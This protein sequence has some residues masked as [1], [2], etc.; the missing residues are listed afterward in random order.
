METEENTPPVEAEDPPPDEGG[1]PEPQEDDGQEERP[2]GVREAVQSA[3][4]RMERGESLTPGEEDD[5]EEEPEAGEA[6]AA[7]AEEGERET[8]EVPEEGPGEEEPEAE[9]EGSEPEEEEEPEAEPGEEEGE[10]PEAEYATIELPPRSEGEDPI[11]VDVPKELEEHFN[12]LNNGYARREEANRVLAKAQEIRD[13]VAEDR[14]EIDY[15]DTRLREDPVGFVLDHVKEPEIRRNLFLELLAENEVWE[16]EEL[17]NRMGRWKR[18]PEARELF[19]TK[20]ERDRY[21]RERER[22][23]EETE[24][25]A[26]QAGVR[27]TAKEIRSLMPEE[28]DTVPRNRFYNDALNDMA[29]LAGRLGRTKFTREEIVD[30]LSRTGLLEVYGIDPDAAGTDAPRKGAAARG[31]A[32]QNGDG[33]RKRA[34]A[35]KPTA[36]DAQQTQESLKEKGKRARAARG[37]GPEGAGAPA[38]TRELPKE[39]VKERIARVRKHG[40]ASVTGT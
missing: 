9:E 8:S 23:Q 33:A 14:Q 31:K 34:R 12:R 37:Y 21:K 35:R 15:I 29:K 26:V 36:E 1:S 11:S 24:R 27:E 13:E 18:D 16:D 40:V 22:T 10:E 28:M 17:Q 2:T 4:E 5:A 6:P 39:G 7:E 32:K 19:R 3:R 25:R 20:V 30:H 38:A